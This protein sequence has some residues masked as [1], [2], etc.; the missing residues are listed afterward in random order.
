MVRVI[1][2]P[3]A[4][5]GDPLGVLEV[6]AR[7]AE[8]FST[9]DLA[10][11]QGIANLLG[12]AIDRL[13]SA[14][15]LRER[16]EWA[17]LVVE[18]LRDHAVFTVDG[19]GRITSWNSGARE[20][21]GYD[22]KEALGLDCAMLFTAEDREAGRPAAEL[23]AAR[24]SGVAVSERW[25]SA[26]DGR[27]FWG[28]G[29]I[30]PLHDSVGRNRGY[31]KI[32]RDRTEWFLAQQQAQRMNVDL[33]RRVAER[34]AA[35]LRSEAALHQAQKMEAIGTSTGMVAHDFNNVLTAI[36]GYL[37][38]LEDRVKDDATA[39][40]FVGAALRAGARGE[41]MAQ[42]LLAFSRHQPGTP[43]EIDVNAAIRDLEELMLRSIGEGIELHL[44]LAP[45]L[46]RIC[47]DVGHFERALLNLVLNA[48]DV[49]P[50]G[51]VLGVRTSRFMLKPELAQIEAIE[52]GPYVRIGITDTG[53]G[54]KEEVRE[55]AFEPFFTTKP[56][57]AGTGLGL[58]MVYG[59]ARQSKGR[60]AI[61]AG[62]GG[63]GTEVVID[64]PAARRS[65]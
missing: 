27:R 22:E 23:T 28:S 47:V 60:A 38:L 9:Q 1:E 39:S 55:R 45:D 40:R 31:L 12:V 57:G 5:A 6:G 15:A 58:S 32:L 10:F 51:G 14:A 42:Q 43:E 2:V 19:D 53:P 33:E 18:G 21:L 4:G 26:K 50:D 7:G 63:V 35:L 59:F 52:A 37:A 46:P 64:L 24:T 34:S 61:L 44:D 11:V 54:M 29:T 8:A 13:L 62:P 25:H 30:R 17:R 41:R 56:S 65:G 3:V 16:E 20:L 36:L 48:R 49:M